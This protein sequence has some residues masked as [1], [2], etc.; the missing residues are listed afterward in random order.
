MKYTYTETRI[1]KPSDIYS[2]RMLPKG[3]GISEFRPPKRDEIY[4]AAVESGHMRVAESDY[5]ITAPRF[6][7]VK[8]FT[9]DEVWE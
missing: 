3:Y 1:I 9:I 8:V 2:H 6:I 7:L 5:P 4:L